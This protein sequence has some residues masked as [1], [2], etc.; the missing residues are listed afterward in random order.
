MFTKQ[1]TERAV[2]DFKVIFNEAMAYADEKQE[3][4]ALKLGV[5]QA[6]ISNYCSPISDRNFPMG[7]FIL[8]P[9]RMIR[10]V[11]KYFMAN[12]KNTKEKCEDLN[13]SIDD[14]IVAMVQFEADLKRESE[15]DLRKA[16]KTIE[17]LRDWLDRSEREI[18]FMHKKSNEDI[19]Q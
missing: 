14:E 3:T 11:L 17:K 6:Q 15:T 13:G 8:L 9:N 16:L 19:K 2:K 10:Y 5:T 7:M 12:V 1:S 18:E 4:L